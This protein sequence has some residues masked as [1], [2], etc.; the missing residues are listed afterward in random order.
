MMCV[1]DK[2]NKMSCC[3]SALISLPKPK[4][5]VKELENQTENL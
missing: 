2:V 4:N 1:L 3:G 5:R